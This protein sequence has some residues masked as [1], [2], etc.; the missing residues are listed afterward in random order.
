MKRNLLKGIV[1]IALV[2]FFLFTSGGTVTAI[3]Y[4]WYEKE[5]TAAGWQKIEVKVEGVA[6]QILWKAPQGVWTNGVIIALHGGGGSYT[7]WCA[8]PRATEP[9]IAF[10]ALAIKNGFAVFALDSADGVYTDASGNSCGKRFRCTA[11]DNTPNADLDFIEIVLSKIIPERRSKKSARDIFITGVSNGGFT[12]ILAA[13]HFDDKI[14]AFA[15]VSAGDPYGTSI[16]CRKDLTIREAAPGLFYDNETRK[17]IG[18]DDSCLADAYPR[19]QSWQSSDP[20]SKPA[21]KQF[22]NEKD[23]GV[24]ISCMQKAGKLLREHGYKDD[25]AFI[26]KD[27]GQKRIWKHFWLNAYNQ[28]IIQ[29]F[30]KN[31]R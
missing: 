11:E 31:K 24:D 25:G 27:A 17:N 9:M 2:L 12:T 10:S 21:F 26:K 3:D 8:G 4:P 14:T 1:T 19:E 18:E 29:F 23:I 6:R 15:P 28:P 22:H 7:N 16:D 20:A 13:T 30:I 5:C